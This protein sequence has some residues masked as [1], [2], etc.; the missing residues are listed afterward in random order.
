VYEHLKSRLA[1]MEELEASTP[2]DPKQWVRD[3]WVSTRTGLKLVF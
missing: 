2:Q 1:L 3:S